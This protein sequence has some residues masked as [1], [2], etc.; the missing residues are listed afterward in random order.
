MK[1]LLA[2]LVLLMHAAV[3]AIAQPAGTGQRFT[4]SPVHLTNLSTRAMITQYSTSSDRTPIIAPGLPEAKFS[5]DFTPPILTSEVARMV[6]NALAE[7]GILVIPDGRIFALI[8]PKSWEKTVQPLG[9]QIRNS[10]ISPTNRMVT[11]KDFD[12]HDA[13]IAQ[14][15]NVYVTLARARIEPGSE[16]NYPGKIDFIIYHPT[17]R[18][19]T[20]YAL[21]TLLLWN[22]VK[23]N[24]LGT[25]LIRAEAIQPK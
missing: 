18:E 23:I 20:M 15:L 25:N 6:T 3:A 10:P 1:R 9:A 8:V 24:F 17:T 13:S 2:L 19:E 11:Y 21:R 12:L 22:N 7:K 16:T 4:I 5:L 14:V